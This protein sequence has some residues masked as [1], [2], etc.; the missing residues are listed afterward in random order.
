MLECCHHS[1]F[2]VAIVE[3]KSALGRLLTM[4]QAEAPDRAEKGL[5]IL[6][7]C[8][9]GNSPNAPAQGKPAA[10]VAWAYTKIEA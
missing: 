1:A 3:T 9:L 10:V 8:A 4:I 5:A 2:Q 6:L 7:A